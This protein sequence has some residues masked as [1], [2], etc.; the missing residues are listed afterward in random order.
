MRILVLLIGALVGAAAIVAF[1]GQPP[2]V[3]SA[4]ADAP[5]CTVLQ[6]LREPLPAGEPGPAQLVL[7]LFQG[8]P[9]S[10]TVY[11]EGSPTGIAQFRYAESPATGFFPAAQQRAFLL[12]PGAYTLEVSG[13]AGR[14]ST[15]LSLAEGDSL[16]F[17][18]EC[19]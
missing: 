14:L 17:A 11:A 1:G 16:M 15:G 2:A 5:G 7:V 4:Q 9:T 8:F 18:V 19:M 10:A 12:Q 13:R 3:Q 6:E